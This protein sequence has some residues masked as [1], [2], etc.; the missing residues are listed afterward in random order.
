MEL[1]SGAMHQN[2]SD[3]FECEKFEDVRLY[4]SPW[5]SNMKLIKT[6]GSHAVEFLADDLEEGLIRSE[7][8]L[9]KKVF[10]M[11]GNAVLGWERIIYLFE[12]PYR[13]RSSGSVC[14]LGTY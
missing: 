10:E 13:I 1:A 6:F 2:L 9:Q 4:S 12:K 3:P 8:E 7:E 14:S 5:I 11:G